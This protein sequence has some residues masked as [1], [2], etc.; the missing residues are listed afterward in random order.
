ME[1]SNFHAKNS[2]SNTRS[3]DSYLS[4]GKGKRSS[5]YG[6]SGSISPKQPPRRSTRHKKRTGQNEIITIDSSDDGIDSSDDDEVSGL[7]WKLYHA[8]QSAIYQLIYELICHPSHF[9]LRFYR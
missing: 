5:Q 9:H 3:I 4:G 2:K 1:P 8:C 6:E 7:L